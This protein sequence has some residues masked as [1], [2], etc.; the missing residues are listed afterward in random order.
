MLAQN[1]SPPTISSFSKL[2]FVLF[3][4]SHIL[5]DTTRIL[6]RLQKTKGS[7][8]HVALNSILFS[9]RLTRQACIIVWSRHYQVP[10]H[11]HSVPGCCFVNT[12]SAVPLETL[13][14]IS[15]VSKLFAAALCQFPFDSSWATTSTLPV[16]SVSPNWL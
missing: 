13:P 9:A 15:F 5:T 8:D 6:Q 16:L 3:V 7:K 14:C 1:H 12:Y 2:F 4:L 10:C 11:F